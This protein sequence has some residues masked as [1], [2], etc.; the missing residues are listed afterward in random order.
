MGSILDFKPRYVKKAFCID[1]AFS[2]KGCCGWAII[3]LD[4]AMFGGVM[5]K[6][7]IDQCGVLQPFSSESS[8]R[9]MNDL[10]KNLIEIWRNNSGYSREPSVIIVER[11]VTYPGSPVRHASIEKLNL[12]V[13][14]LLTSLA[15]KFQLSPSPNEWKGNK[16]KEQTEAEIISLLSF[17]DRTALE[18]DLR[19]IKAYQRHNVFDAI[20][21]GIYG[22]QVI[23]KKIS[24]PEMIHFDEDSKF[25]E[26][27]ANG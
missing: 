5:N 14:T 15:P 8:L 2:H 20:G 22:A 7:F 13:G 21:L 4:A 26:S 6:P 10:R 1:P 23:T 11:P 16:S 18:R 17:N 19:C 9:T 25:F 3:N 27:M 12:F 24:P